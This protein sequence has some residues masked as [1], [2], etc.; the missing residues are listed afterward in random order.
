MGNWKLSLIVAVVLF[1]TFSW[2]DSM[3]AKWDSRIPLPKGAVLISSTQPTKGVVYSADFRV[4]GDYKEL[5]D[6]YQTAI[7]K[8]GF[9][10]GPKAAVPARKVCNFSFNTATSLDSV[11]ITPDAAHPGSFILHISYVPK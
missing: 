6:F 4:A 5:V 3:P 9:E 7:P 8:S 2:A 10:M 1:A 11:L